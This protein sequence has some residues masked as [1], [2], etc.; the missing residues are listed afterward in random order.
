MKSWRR[1]RQNDVDGPIQIRFQRRH[2]MEEL[3]VLDLETYD[4][5]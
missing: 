2:L 5:S 3:R 4:Y 1:L